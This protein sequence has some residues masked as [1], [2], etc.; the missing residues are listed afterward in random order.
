MNTESPSPASPSSPAIPTVKT[1]LNRNDRYFSTKERP[2]SQIYPSSIFK[3]RTELA[4]LNEP[5]NRSPSLLTRSSE[6]TQNEIAETNLILAINSK[7]VTLT[8][9]LGHT[10]G[11]IKLSI[12]D[13]KNKTSI[14]LK[15]RHNEN[16]KVEI[17]TNQVRCESTAGLITGLVTFWNLAGSFEHAIS[18]DYP[19]QH[20][21]QLTCGVFENKAEYLNNC[22]FMIRILEFKTEL[23]DEWHSD[24]DLFNLKI[25]GYIGWETIQTMVNNNT[26]PNALQI[27]AHFDDFIESQK[28]HSQRAYMKIFAQPTDETPKDTPPLKTLELDAQRLSHHWFWAVLTQAPAESIQILCNSG[29]FTH[30][31]RLGGSLKLS[32]KAVA[33]SIFQGDKFR[34]DTWTLISLNDVTM[35]YDT[36]F[37]EVDHNGIVAHVTHQNAA[38]CMGNFSSLSLEVPN[39]K[40]GLVEKCV[41]NTKLNPPERTDTIAMWLRYACSHDFAHGNPDHIRSTRA[42]IFG[43]GSIEYSI[44]FQLPEMKLNLNTTHNWNGD[45]DISP[46]L[47]RRLTIPVVHC[48]LKSLFKGSIGLATNAAH[49]FFLHD[50][51]QRYTKRMEKYNESKK[52]NPELPTITVESLSGDVQEKVNINH[53]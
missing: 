48:K 15:E 31:L 50:L 29:S 41:R 9:N 2:E 1:N 28:K 44:I 20:M 52:S 42:T 17:F 5:R 19:S 14:C 4:N 49:Y 8:T 26:A 53:V 24:T 10:L 51:A 32:G 40:I 35:G 25:G 27:K 38:I 33:V 12:V 23:H 36:S 47:S 30:P 45:G 7:E 22:I 43:T 6:G 46:T 18:P 34:D 3:D 37:E 16:R 21:I 39:D 13:S 11:R